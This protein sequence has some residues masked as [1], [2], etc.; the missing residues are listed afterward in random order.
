MKI[1]F[2]GTNGWYDTGTGNT[3]CVLAETKK[4]Y[5]IFDAGSGLPK[6]DKYIKSNKPVVLLLSHY[7]IDHVA[8]L[9]ALAKFNFQQGMDIYGPPGLKTFF[10]R[11]INKPYTI[12]ITRLKFKVRLHEISSQGPLPSGITCKPLKHSD[13]CYGYRVLADGKTLA[14]CTDT[15]LCGNILLLARGADLF[16]SECSLRSG[17]NNP[18]WPHLN[19]ESAAGV[20][21]KAGAKKLALIH[22]DA[23]L[24]LNFGQRA[25][26]ARQSKKIF[27]NSFVTRDNLEIRL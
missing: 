18:D 2:L 3:V 4:R 10:R 21:L 6:V 16:I 26:A 11:V 17:Q 9:H 15:G 8:G 23:S 1:H 7:H 27:K 25:K 20:A 13:T 12:P 14:Y 5:I 19:P 22:F 24:Y